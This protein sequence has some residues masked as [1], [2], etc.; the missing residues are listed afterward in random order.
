MLAVE[1]YLAE[2]EASA[3][4]SEVLKA[5]IPYEILYWL[6]FVKR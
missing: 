1:R 3:A 4:A 6:T 5:C 2:M